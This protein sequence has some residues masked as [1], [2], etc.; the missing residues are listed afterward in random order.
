MTQMQASAFRDAENLTKWTCRLLYIEIAIAVIALMSGQLEHRLLSDLSN[1]AFA[2]EAEATLQAEASDLRQA[3]VAAFQFLSAVTSGVLVLRWIHRAN[4]NAHQLGALDMRF[5]P[6]WSIGWY[7]IP[8]ANLWKPYQ[9]MKEIWQASD[10]PKNWPDREVPGLIPSWW[11]FWIITNLL[12]NATF[13]LS[14]HADQVDQM[15][16]VNV[17]SQICDV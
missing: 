16:Y 8:F 17:L 11:F 14:L 12:G 3:I 7:F 10:E 1:G 6:G 4:F 2:S 13:R 9:A 15:L 5:T